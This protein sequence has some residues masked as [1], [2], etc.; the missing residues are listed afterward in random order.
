MLQGRRMRIKG[1]AF[2]PRGHV[3]GS[4]VLSSAGVKD[5][6]PGRSHPESIR[7]V[8]RVVRS[9]EQGAM[10]TLVAALGWVVCDGM[11]C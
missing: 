8:S 7:R 2:L 3:L 4:C 11:G 6:K 9:P 5:S 1:V 10:S